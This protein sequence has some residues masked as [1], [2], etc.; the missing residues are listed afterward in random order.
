VRG[1][2]FNPQ[3]YQNKKR[4]KEEKR[5]GR[6]KRGNHFSRERLS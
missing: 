2:V 4:R 6:R 5:E 3:Y 1:S